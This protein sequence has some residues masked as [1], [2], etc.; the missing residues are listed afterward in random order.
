MEDQPKPTL[1]AILW[2]ILAGVLF[3]SIAFIVG[4]K[5]GLVTAIDAAGITAG[6]YLIALT[7][8]V[9]RK[10]LRW[11]TRIWAYL[12]VGFSL[13]IIAFSWYQTQH[14]TEQR[15]AIQREQMAERAR[16]AAVGHMSRLFQRTLQEYYQGNARSKETLSDIFF[17]Q[18]PAINDKSLASALNV[19][20]SSMRRFFSSPAPD[21]LV[22]VAQAKVKGRSPDFRN[23][24][25][26]MGS[27]QEKMILTTKGMIHVSEN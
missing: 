26:T 27:I 19:D 1:T 23:I 6:V 3:V 17:R 22:L 2:W 20:G 4:S 25:S 5:S 24:D 9:V 11:S 14:T 8:F 15:T 21:S 18:Y 7:L 13:G 10:P 12:I 16:G